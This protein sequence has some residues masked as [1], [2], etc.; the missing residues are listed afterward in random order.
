[1]P[2]LLR[3]LLAAAGS[4]LV[5]ATVLAAIRT[6]VVPRSQ[7]VWLTRWVF[8]AVRAMFDVRAR[9]AS[10]YAQ[11]DAVMALYAPVAL[12]TLPV[13]W[14]AFILLAYAAIYLGL[15]LNDAGDAVVLSGSSL[16][17]LGS[18]SASGLPMS[19]VGFSEAGVGLVLLSLLIAY[20]PTIYSSF[21]RREAAVTLLAVR[22]GSPPSAVEMFLRFHRLGRL[23]KLNELWTSW[24][25]WFA[26]V[27]ESH[28]SLAVLSF[29]R[30]PQPEHSWVTAAGAVLD[31]ASLRTSTLD[32]PPDPQADLC[33]RAGYLCLRRIADLFRL[34][35]DS[36]PS[37]D[38]PISIAREEFDDVYDRLRE[39][40]VPLKNDRDA[41]W[42]A[43]AGWRVNYDS[44]LVG[45][46]ELMMA[47]EAPWS[48]DRGLV[49]AGRRR[50][51]ADFWR[52]V[53]RGS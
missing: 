41:A 14:L 29:F 15:G 13:V 26:E 12:L 19:L 42:R 49:S 34:P 6:F 17:T 32:L 44:V 10:T 9:R 2:L 48:S 24:E 8:L 20:L 7:N 3:V 52:Y 36:N 33:I 37:E 43:F 1:M 16:F 21:S 35:Y 11:R 51:R 23:E 18:A 5:A 45:L 46:A 28:T 40:G 27:E 53:L 31:A 25:A 30:S 22:A 50:S 47:P 39:H 38:A 4:G